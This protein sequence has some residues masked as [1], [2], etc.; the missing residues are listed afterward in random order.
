MFV[1]IVT[2]SFALCSSEGEAGWT[3]ATWNSR[4]LP[5][6]SETGRQNNERTRE[7]HACT[8]A[9]GPSAVVCPFSSF[10]VRWRA[11]SLNANLCC[12][13]PF[14]S[15][16]FHVRLWCGTPFPSWDNPWPFSTFLTSARQRWLRSF[17]TWPAS[18]PPYH[19]FGIT[20]SLLF[21]LEAGTSRP[22]QLC[23]SCYGC[24]SLRAERIRTRLRCIE[25]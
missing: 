6:L 16:P 19:R 10:R 5:R 13:P 18:C 3:Q 9:Q 7:R 20:H 22:K 14:F 24:T 12:Y 21:P 25:R 1:S 8:P 23:G 2:L 4:G 11:T 17:V 15:F